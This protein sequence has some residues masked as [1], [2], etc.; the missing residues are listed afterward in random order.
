[1]NAK[2]RAVDIDATGAVFVTGSDTGGVRTWC[3][4][5]NG[6]LQWDKSQ[7]I[8]GGYIGQDIAVA[9]SGPPPT[10]TRSA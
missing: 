5:G 8:G 2:A 10:S 6:F 3:F 9:P 7:P 4:D 1:V